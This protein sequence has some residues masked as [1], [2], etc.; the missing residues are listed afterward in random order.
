[1][2]QQQALSILRSSAKTTSIEEG[3]TMLRKDKQQ[4]ILPQI[5]F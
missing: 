3:C 1:M 4:R 2:Q 5:T